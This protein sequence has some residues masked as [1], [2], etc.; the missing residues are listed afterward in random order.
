MLK[1]QEVFSKNGLP[2][3]DAETLAEPLSCSTLAQLK[4]FLDAVHI[5]FCLVKPFQETKG[6]PLVESRELLPSFDNDMF[7]HKDLPGFAMVAF[8]RQLHYFSEIFQYDKLHPVITEVEGVPCCPL[9]SQ[10]YHQNLETLASRL[11]RLH[12]ELSRRSEKLP[13]R[14]RRKDG[15]A[16]CAHRRGERRPQESRVVLLIPTTLRNL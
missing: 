9:E 13:A 10:V 2:W 15:A 1:W 3:Q 6:Y 4:S 11:P 8:A 14:S 12:Q 7:E 5:R 16:S